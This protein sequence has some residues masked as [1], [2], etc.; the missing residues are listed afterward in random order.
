MQLSEVLCTI[1]LLLSLLE[2][3]VYAQG[4]KCPK[5][6]L[7]NGR[8]KMRARGKFAYFKCKKRYTRLGDRFAVCLQSETWSHP[9]PICIS[10]GC[11]PPN[12]EASPRIEVETSYNGALLKFTCPVGTKRTGPEV[13]TCN[14]REWSEDPPT[15]DS[16]YT[17]E[18]D[19]EDEGICGWSQD[20]FDNFEWTRMSG[21]TPTMSTGPPG[22]HTTG[23]GF[24]LFIESSSPRKAGDTARLISPAYPPTLR[25]MCFEFWYHMKG[26]SDDDAVGSLEVYILPTSVSIAEIDPEFYLD[27]N[28]GNEWHRGL[29]KIPD[30]DEIFKIVIVGTR[31]EA[32]VSD[33]A[34]DDLRMYNCSEV[35]TTTMA[36][37]TTTPPTT[38]TVTVTTSTTDSVVTA[39]RVSSTTSAN[40]T[41]EMAKNV[42]TDIVPSV[43]TTLPVQ[44]TTTAKPMTTSSVAPITTTVLTT[45]QTT[46]TTTSTSATS[47]TS[48]TTKMTTPQRQTSTVRFSAKLSTKTKA[49][50]V[51][52]T[53][54][55]AI[56]T[57]T[58]PT[59][60]QQPTST[61]T[62]SAVTS[63]Y[64]FTSE[65][66]TNATNGN[67]TAHKGESQYITHGLQSTSPHPDE[68]FTSSGDDDL[69][70]G[71][72]INTTPA[73]VK[74]M[75]SAAAAATTSA[76]IPAVAD[77]RNTKKST[78][79]GVMPL[80]IGI[81]AG[82]VVGMIVIGILAWL[83]TRNQRKKKEQEAAEDE[84]NMLTTSDAA[85]YNYN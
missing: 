81:S 33:I 77:V 41:R 20:T 54:S 2:Q 56:S 30:Q 25:N 5:L 14:G 37:T 12:L 45:L 67:V 57:T 18:C 59:S 66:Q 22:D 7:P 1:T 64:S 3:S 4:R 8:V 76:G 23:S 9:T 78:G 61:S 73:T 51:S 32:F 17:M 63:V 43:K 40:S 52:M 35:T 53:S 11:S 75:T 6:S 82:I 38:T 10:R 15:C 48:T 47:T 42:T 60:T 58:A 13:I 84:L 85:S 49:P 34:I 26:P 27:G 55:P 28:Q 39:G 79:G 80:I 70:T 46:P 29:V 50:T 44:A 83:W 71:N 62:S 31:K 65:A 72:D 69:F 68:K 36:S 16:G 21:T 24:Y 74:N 19:F